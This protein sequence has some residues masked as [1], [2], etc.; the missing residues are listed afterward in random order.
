MDFL[1]EINETLKQCDRMSNSV[2]K[3]A[4]SNALRAKAEVLKAW[5]IKDLEITITAH[6][7]AKRVRF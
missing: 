3:E 2:N 1:E 6:N 5:A 7:A 4:A